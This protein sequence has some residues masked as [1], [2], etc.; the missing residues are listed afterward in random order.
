M[1]S[2]AAWKR[3]L[4][5]N[6]DAQRLGEPARVFCAS[7]ADVFEDHPQVGDAR[8]RLWDLIEDTPW[9]QWQLLTKRIENVAAMVPWGQSW[10]SWVWI[11]TS[12]ENQTWAGRRIAVLL[13]LPAAIRF[14][15]CEPLLGPLNLR[16]WLSDPA[17]ID[18][19]LW[20]PSNVRERSFDWVI[21]GGESGRRA[22]PMHPAWAQRIRD[23][24]QAAR[25]P[26]FL[27][28]FGEYSPYVPMVADATRPDGQRPDWDRAHVW[29]NQATGAVT[30]E[31][32]SALDGG[33][34]WHAM[35]RVGKKAA[36]RELDGVTWNQFPSAL[37]GAAA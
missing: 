36:G 35:Y 28:Q 16:P 8:K 29:V 10:P 14:L 7:M 25:V 2:D 12:V 21:A 26:F 32:D 31:E 3:P 9:L 15:S 11:G 22:R 4:I 30:A 5:W 13:G 6:R 27:K 18:G 17:W 34:S 33:G 24:C 23:D 1:L 19:D 37:S 20:P